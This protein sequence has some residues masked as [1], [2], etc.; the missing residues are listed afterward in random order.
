[1]KKLFVLVIALL[2]NGVSTAL[3]PIREYKV[4]PKEFGMDFDEV[5]LKTDDNLTLF[6]WYFNSPSKSGRA[7]ILS[8]DGDGNM[9]DLIELASNFVTLGYNVLT[10]DYRGYGKSDDFEINTNFYIYAQ[11]EKDLNAA[12]DYVRLKKSGITSLSLYGEGMGAGL[13]LAVTS[14]NKRISKVIADSP[15]SN[16][17]AMKKRIKEVHGIDM[18]FPL[19][20]NKLTLEP[21]YALAQT[22]AQVKRYLF[23]CGDSD[24]LC[25]PKDLKELSKIVKNTSTIYIVKKATSENTFSIDKAKYFEEIRKF[26]N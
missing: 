4:T 6:G 14:N 9:A 2:L 5:T 20:F 17:E 7:I 24:K 18:F 1:M 19:A 26:L 11:F 8:H 25:T 16:F 10:Y 12:M 3:N 21:V 13:S 15:Y 22:N 23:I